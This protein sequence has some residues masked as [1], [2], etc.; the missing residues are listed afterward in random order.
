MGLKDN[1]T[2]MADKAKVVAEKSGEKIAGGVGKVTET[3][4]TKTGGKHHDKLAKVD[5]LAAK[6]DKT[7]GG[8]APAADATPEPAADVAPEPVADVAPEPTA[9]VTPEPPAGDTPTAS[10]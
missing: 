7:A 8:E 4:D 9:S 6:L 5:S 3:I 1:L 2:K 10:S